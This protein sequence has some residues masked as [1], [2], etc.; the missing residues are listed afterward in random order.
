MGMIGDIAEGI[1]AVGQIAVKP[2][3]AIALASGALLYAPAHA[4]AATGLADFLAKYRMWIGFAL[5]A[6]SA[7]LLAHGALLHKS[8]R[9]AAC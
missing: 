7:Y 2:L 3:L 9:R 8:G 5:L 4:I 1:K 6:S